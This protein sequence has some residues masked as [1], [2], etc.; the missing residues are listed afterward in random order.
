MVIRLLFVG[1]LSSFVFPGVPLTRWPADLLTLSF[2]YQLTLWDTILSNLANI[3]V[4]VSNIIIRVY[5]S[6][7]LLPDFF[8][9]GSSQSPLRTP[10]GV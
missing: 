9:L 4:Q 10:A 5:Y 6:R 8:G 3:Q 7:N 1:I 2:M